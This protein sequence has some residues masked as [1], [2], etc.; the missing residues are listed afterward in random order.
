MTAYEPLDALHEIGIHGFAAIQLDVLQ[1]A[2][3][4]GV[5]SFLES[6]FEELD[7]LPLKGPVPARNLLLSIGT[8]GKRL[9]Q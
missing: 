1:T 3:Q 5:F 2:R 7:I 6:F 4:D 9:P 8:A